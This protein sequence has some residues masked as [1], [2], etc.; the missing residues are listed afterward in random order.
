M[1]PGPE[2]RPVPDLALTCLAQ[3]EAH[4]AAGNPAKAVELLEHALAIGIA[5]NG[6]R[7][8]VLLPSPTLTAAWARMTAPRRRGAVLTR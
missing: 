2:E 7:R 6:E 4:L 8:A 1:V 5:D 3:A